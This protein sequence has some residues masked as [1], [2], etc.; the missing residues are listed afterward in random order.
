MSDGVPDAEQPQGSG[1][2]ATIH[3]GRLT[4][5]V[6]NPYQAKAGTNG[7]TTFVVFFGDLDK[8]IAD[9]IIANGAVHHGTVAS[10]H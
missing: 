3:K 1:C 6:S 8:L 10:V 2:Q 4:A 9:F 7:K 5:A